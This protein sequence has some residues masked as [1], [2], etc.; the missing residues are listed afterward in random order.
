MK[1]ERLFDGFMVNE[2]RKIRMGWK[3]FKINLKK[4]LKYKIIDSS[5]S[6]LW[7]KGK[8]KEINKKIHCKIACWREKR[9]AGSSFEVTGLVRILIFKRS[10]NV[11]F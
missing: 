4:W 3:S 9:F 2:T 10:I 11:Y 7:V 1:L 6:F 5:F 8:G